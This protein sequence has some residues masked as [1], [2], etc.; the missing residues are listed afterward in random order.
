MEDFVKFNINSNIVLSPIN[1]NTKSK[2]YIDYLQELEYQRTTNEMRWDDSNRNTT[3]IPGGLFGFVHNYKRIE[4]SLI[5]K[6]ETLSLRRESWRENINQNDRK[7]LI[8]SPIIKTIQWDD[9]IN[10]GGHKKVQGT[11]VLKTNKEHI[12]NSIILELKDFSYYIDTSEF[13]K[14]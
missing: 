11:T 14:N 6:I 4:F 12:F 3:S 1:K 9:W 8:L 5:V 2:S 13:I 7:V 10:M